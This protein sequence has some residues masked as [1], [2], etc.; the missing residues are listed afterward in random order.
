M[1]VLRGGDQR[2]R[3]IA[4]LRLAAAD[5]DSTRGIEVV[6]NGFAALRNRARSMIRYETQF[7]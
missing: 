3:L 4:P 2:R 7:S 5:G 1:K 6:R